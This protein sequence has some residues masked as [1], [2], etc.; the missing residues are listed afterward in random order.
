IRDGE[1]SLPTFATFH[2]LPNEWSIELRSRYS[3]QY[4]AGGEMALID[5]IR[6]NY[7]FSTGAWQGYQGQD[8]TA[9]I[10]LGR[11]RDISKLGAGFLQDVGSWIWMPRRVEFEL[12]VDGKLFAAPIVIEND[13]PDKEYNVVVKD[14]VKTISTQPVRYVR[15]TAVSYGLIPE[16]HPGKGGHSW[17]FIDEI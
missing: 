16:W 7:N 9:L 10:D 13:V 14:L 2:K 4:A 6:G 1:Q 5:G 8:L 15:V 12:S 3:P 11:I 17:I